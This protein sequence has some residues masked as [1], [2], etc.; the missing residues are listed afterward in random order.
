MTSPGLR[1]RKKLATWRQIRAAALRLFNERGFEAVSIEEIAAAADVS[2]T[3]FFNYFSG[4]EAVVFDPDPEEPEQW[5]AL[6]AARPEDEPVWESLTAVLLDY[7]ERTADR[8]IVRKRLRDRSPAL[9]QGAAD[10]RD[11][12]YAELRGWAIARHTVRHELRAILQVNLA[13]AAVMTAYERWDPD[14]P[15]AV[16][17]GLM[18]TCLAQ[19]GAGL[20]DVVVA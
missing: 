10:R 20:G 9:A 17:L 8:V 18:R 2:R 6:L 3:T 11:R 7:T 14:E 13:A 19:A 16:L 1:E 4:K 12:F 5:R 15:F